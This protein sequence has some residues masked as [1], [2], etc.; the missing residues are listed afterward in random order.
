M[1]I[2]PGRTPDQEQQKVGVQGSLHTSILGLNRASVKA[3]DAGERIAKG[4][5]EDPKNTVDL[6]TAER[7]FQASVKAIQSG[8]QMTGILLD[9]KT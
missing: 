4:G 7:S 5:A 9:L 3:A 6:I 8:E 1:G 2:G